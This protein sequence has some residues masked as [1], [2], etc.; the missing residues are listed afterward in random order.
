MRPGLAAGLLA[1]ALVMTSCTAEETGGDAPASPPAATGTSA[2]PDT[3][4]AVVIPPPPESDACYLLGNDE[5]TRPTNESDP[6]PCRRKHTAQTFFVGKL[7]MVYDGHAVAVDSRRVQQQVSTAC[8]RRFASYVGGSEQDRDLSRLRVVWFSPTLEQA[9]Q[10]ADWFRCDLVAFGDGEDLAT[11]RQPVRRDVL[12]TP[13]GRDTFGLCGTSAP[14]EPGFR[15]VLCSADHTW[16]A[17]TTLP[18]DG[19]ARYP[20]AD[21]VRE[22]GDSDCADLVRESL[23][24]PLTFTYGWE[25]PTRD[26]WRAGQRFGYCWSPVS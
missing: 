18:L 2:P 6:V 9:D 12:A 19:E 1:V 25:W 24:F 7:R 11:R 4:P 26:Q 10:G 15:R 14:G 17:L 5:L 8:P 21:A 3:S 23:D 13:E 16:R 22:A 20:G